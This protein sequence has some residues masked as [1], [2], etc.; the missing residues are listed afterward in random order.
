VPDMR[1]VVVGNAKSGR[2]RI[3]NIYIAFGP[4]AVIVS[5]SVL[6]T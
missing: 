3:Q 5:R 6:N 4:E 2:K 1:G